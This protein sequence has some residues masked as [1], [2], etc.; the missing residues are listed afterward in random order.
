MSSV[1]GGW[2]SIARVKG[3]EDV[4]E[5]WGRDC[6]EVVPHCHLGSQAPM[7]YGG[8]PTAQPAPG[9]WRYGSISFSGRGLALGVGE[10]T[11]IPRFCSGLLGLWATEIYHGL[12]QNWLHV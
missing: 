2:S 8:R 9:G 11:Y 6:E 3:C 10:L 1:R 5:A 4:K 12:G 7:R